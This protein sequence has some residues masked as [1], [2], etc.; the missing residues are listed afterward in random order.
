MTVPGADRTRNFWAVGAAATAAATAAAA[1]STC[2]EHGRWS[3]M[4]SE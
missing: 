3:C 4:L 2:S 1:V